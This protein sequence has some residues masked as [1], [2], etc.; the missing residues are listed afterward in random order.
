M[1]SSD[2]IISQL[3]LNKC[4]LLPKGNL[5]SSIRCCSVEIIKVGPYAII[6]DEAFSESY[7]SFSYYT[8][9]TICSLDAQVYVCPVEVNF[10]LEL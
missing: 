4:G 5:F 1:Q 9:A 2:Q 8:T 6:G 10:F 7:A 3:R